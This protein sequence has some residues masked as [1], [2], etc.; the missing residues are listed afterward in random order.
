[1][2]I[3][4]LHPRDEYGRFA[5][6]GKSGFWDRLAGG[7][8]NRAHAANIA[9]FKMNQRRQDLFSAKRDAG[10]LTSAEDSEW[11]VLGERANHLARNVLPRAHQKGL[12]PHSDGTWRRPG[13]THASNL[14]DA[15]GRKLPMA[16]NQ[17]MV[18]V[19]DHPGYGKGPDDPQIPRSGNSDLAGGVWHRP[20]EYAPGKVPIL[21][22]DFGHRMS[23]LDP[24]ES[25]SRRSRQASGTFARA[26]MKAEKVLDR[27]FADR[28]DDSSKVGSSDT[29][30][31]Y[32]TS[33]V[34][35]VGRR[36][37]ARKK[38]DRAQTVTWIQRL[39]D[40]MEGR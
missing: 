2:W 29:F 39:S 3:D 27:R 25:R 14:H 21:R 37:T 11:D 12:Q 40:R 8:A 13:N 5:L 35:P 24:Q 15:E 18:R 16:I 33:G 9:E 20:G 30:G 28:N 36:R 38:R 22:N 6:S 7:E 34:N 32:L 23:Q 4:K 1:M 19:G 10:T 31:S 26:E 17:G